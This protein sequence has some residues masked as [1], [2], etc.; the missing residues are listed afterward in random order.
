MG[1]IARKK[2][3]PLRRESRRGNDFLDDC[4][5]DY[6]LG[7]AGMSIWGRSTLSYEDCQIRLRE[8]GKFLSIGVALPRKPFGWMLV[9]VNLLFHFF[10]LL[11][12]DRYSRYQYTQYEAFW[13][14]DA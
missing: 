1:L 10:F 4:F 7:G 2:F 11:P 6:L 3:P 9:L 14:Y 12:N 5:L 8:S 13:R